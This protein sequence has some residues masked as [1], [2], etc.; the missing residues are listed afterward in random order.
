M[1]SY[2]ILLRLLRNGYT[3]KALLLPKNNLSLFDN[4]AMEAFWSYEYV[5]AGIVSSVLCLVLIILDYI[6]G[7]YAHKLTEWEYPRTQENFE[8]I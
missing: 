2:E 5:V 3:Q 6:F 7:S 4:T 1:A 8:K